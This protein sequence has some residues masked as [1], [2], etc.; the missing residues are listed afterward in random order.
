MRFIQGGVWISAAALALLAVVALTTETA[1]AQFEGVTQDLIGRGQLDY[2]EVVGGP[3]E[4]YV[5]WIHMDPGS[6]YGGWHVHPGPVWVI[7]TGG[8]LTVYGP[9][10][11]PTVYPAG[12]AYVA[13]PDTLYDLRNE[14]SEPVDLAFAGIFRA[15]EPPAQAGQAPPGGC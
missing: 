12:A 5:G 14:A 3:A 15:G 8:S 10:G 13:R 2:S 1:R 7:V 11:C 9:N 6:S 4:I